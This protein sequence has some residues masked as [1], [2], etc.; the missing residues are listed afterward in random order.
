MIAAIQQHPFA[1]V[2]FGF[3]AAVGIVFLVL[4][5]QDIKGRWRI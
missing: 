3:M 4:G 2:F 5:I 1:V